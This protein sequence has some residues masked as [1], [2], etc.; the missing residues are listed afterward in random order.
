MLARG[1]ART[2]PRPA[3]GISDRGV[4]DGGGPRC[5]RSSRAKRRR[6]EGVDRDDPGHT[7][8]ISRRSERACSDS[9]RRGEL[10]PGFPEGPEISVVTPVLAPSRVPICSKKWK[11]GAYGRCRPAPGAPSAGFSRGD[12][13]AAGWCPWR[14]C[15]AGTTRK[16]TATGGDPP[17]YRSRGE[18]SAGCAGA[19]PT[20]GLSTRSGRAREHPGLAGRLRLQIPEGLEMRGVSGQVWIVGPVAIEKEWKVAEHGPAASVAP[21]PAQ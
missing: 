4:T 14:G 18:S 7:S 11:S 1:G 13:S 8:G 15:R 16:V 5:R 12:R 19:S 20:P 6:D 9:G 21:I 2:R 17:S 3:H 10:P